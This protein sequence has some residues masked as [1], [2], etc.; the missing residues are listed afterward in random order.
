LS[1]LN[2]NFV[3]S[4]NEYQFKQNTNIRMKK[5]YYWIAAFLFI[6]F[7]IYFVWEL[8]TNKPYLITPGDYPMTVQFV[9]DTPGIVSIVDKNDTLF[10]EGFSQSLDSSGFVRL[11]GYINNNLP[12]SF[13]FVGRI[14]IFAFEDCCGLIDKNSSWT[15]RRMEKRSFFRLKERNN[16]CCCDS[17]IIYLDIHI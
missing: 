4:R 16:L 6:T 1:Y 13:T 3:E 2:Y 7:C 14:N 11:S 10:V 15:F 17:C 12:D 9:S 8:Y 5:K